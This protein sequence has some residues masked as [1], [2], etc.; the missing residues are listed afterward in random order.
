MVALATVPLMAEIMMEEELYQLLEGVVD[1]LNAHDVPL[2][3]GHSAEGAELSLGLTIV[4]EVELP[5]LSKGALLP[6]DVLLLCKPL[7]TGVLF[8]AN[9]RGRLTSDLMEEVIANMDHSNALAL[10]VLRTHAVRAA[11]DVSGFGLLA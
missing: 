1:V 6:G 5:M 4:G 3:G 10:K 9:M 8:A 2:V 11:T 7:G